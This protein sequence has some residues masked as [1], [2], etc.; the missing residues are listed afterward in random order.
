M[1]EE[2]AV[3]F[4]S[5]FRDAPRAETLRLA[6]RARRDAGQLARATD[7]VASLPG[8]EVPDVWPVGVLVEVR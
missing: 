8:A 6:M 5:A 7:G 2:A 1:G 4:E 3:H